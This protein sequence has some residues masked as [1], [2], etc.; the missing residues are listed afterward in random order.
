V[1][2]C[3]G[4]PGIPPT[5]AQADLGDLLI[6]ALGQG[7]H[8]LIETH[9]EHL[10]LRLRRRIAETTARPSCEVERKLQQDDLGVYFV[11]RQDNR[12]IVSP[13]EVNELGQTRNPPEG[14][15][16]FFS[17]GYEQVMAISETIAEHG[18]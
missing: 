11:E 18:R 7:Y 16:R 15:S 17:D 6:D 10:L 8:F 4:V 3:A 5:R 1:N 2:L 9:S 12:S 13:V 14:F